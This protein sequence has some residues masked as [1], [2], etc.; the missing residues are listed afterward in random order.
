[1]HI[2]NSWAMIISYLGGFLEKYYLMF[3]HILVNALLKLEGIVANLVAT[4]SCEPKN[5]HPWVRPSPRES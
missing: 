5:P 2:L 3:V 4:T 1:M